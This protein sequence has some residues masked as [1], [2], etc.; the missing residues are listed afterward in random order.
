M[1]ALELHGAEREAGVDAYIRFIVVDLVKLL[2]TSTQE[3]SLLKSNQK[4]S[5]YGATNSI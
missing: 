1:P 2:R 5:N 4:S 3:S